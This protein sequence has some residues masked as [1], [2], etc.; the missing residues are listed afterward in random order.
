MT[1]RLDLQMT[2][3]LDLP[4]AS[5]LCLPQTP[6]SVIIPCKTAEN[7]SVENTVRTL[8]TSRYSTPL[9]SPT[10]VPK[11]PYVHV[12]VVGNTVVHDAQNGGVRQARAT[13]GLAG[14]VYRVGNTGSGALPSR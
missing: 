6:V 8:K 9:G 3:R 5:Y 10:T 1:L 2:L 14:W 12:A 4:H 13:W 7:Q 11:V